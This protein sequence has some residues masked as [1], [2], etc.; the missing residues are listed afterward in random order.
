MFQRRRLRQTAS[1]QL[2]AR[3]SDEQCVFKL[4]RALSVHSRRSP[5]VFP[6][7]VLEATL[8]DHRFNRK[9]MAHFHEANR[10]AVSVMWHLWCHVES[11]ADSV[12]CV[13]SNY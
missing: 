9:H 1:E 10:L 2:A 3:L 6:S 7:E 5:F 8:I 13:A 4:S 12:S 11:S